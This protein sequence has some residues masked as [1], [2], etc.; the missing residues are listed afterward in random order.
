MNAKPFAPGSLPCSCRHDRPRA[1]R[2]G[3]RRDVGRGRNGTPVR[4]S[5]P[6]DDD[7][8][9]ESAVALL[10]MRRSELRLTVVE[11]RDELERYARWDVEGRIEGSSIQRL[12]R[13]GLLEQQP[14]RVPNPLPEIPNERDRSRI[15]DWR[16]LRINLDPRPHPTAAACLASSSG[17]AAGR[18]PRSFFKIIEGATPTWR[19]TA[20]RVRPADS[21]AL[22]RS[23]PSSF[24]SRRMSHSARSRRRSRFATQTWS[25]RVLIDGS[26]DCMFSSGEVAAE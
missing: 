8:T 16:S 4:M 25:Q 11:P 12:S 22:R 19:A 1:E 3:G 21:R 9:L 26:R 6:H 7:E 20:R 14:C 24:R 5:R 15:S 13:H 2:K 23:L 18:W 10:E 17:R